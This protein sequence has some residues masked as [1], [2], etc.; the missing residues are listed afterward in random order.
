MLF[1]NRHRP[2]PK[3]RRYRTRHNDYQSLETRNLLAVSFVFESGVLTVNMDQDGNNAIVRNVNGEVTVNDQLVDADAITGGIQALQVS[4]LT[5]LTFAGT[6]GVIDLGAHMAGEFNSGDLVSVEFNNINQA[7]M[8]GLYDV[9]SINGTFVGDNTSFFDADGQ[10]IVN[11]SFNLTSNTSTV[12]DMQNVNNDFRGQINIDTDSNVMIREANDIL[13]GSLNVGTHLT[14]RSLAGDITN[15]GNIHVNGVTTMQ[16]NNVELG[17]GSLVDLN[18]MLLDVDGHFAL[19]EAN[20]VFW[21]GSSQMGST[22]IEAENVSQG[23]FSDVSVVGNAEFDVNRMRLGVGGHNTF[24]T[25]GLNFNAAGHVFI[26]ENSAIQIYGDNSAMDLDLIA[27]GNIENVADSTITVAEISSFQ[28]GQNV[29]IG[30]AANDRFD[31]GTLQFWG[32]IIDVNEDSDMVIDGLANYAQEVVLTA[33]GV[34]TDTDNAYIVV[35]GNARFVSNVTDAASGVMERVTIGDTTSDFFIA[36]TISFDVDEGTFIL[37]ED[38]STQIDGRDGF[39]NH[40]EFAVIRSAG[41]ITNK[42]DTAVIVDKN[43]TFD[44]SSITLGRR[45]GDSFSL[46]SA[47]FKTPGNVVFTEDASVLLG[48]STFVGGNMDIA[49]NGNIQ[50]SQ[51]SFINVLGR[52]SFAGNDIILGDLPGVNSGEPA[53][54][55]FTV[56]PIQFTATG[57]VDITENSTIALATETINTGQTVRLSSVG[58]AQ[59]NGDIT[60]LSGSSLLASGNLHVDA[61]GGI[62]LGAMAGDVI[63]FDNLNFRAAEEVNITAIFADVSDEFFI[64]GSGANKNAASELRLNTNVDVKDGTFAVIEIDEFMR[65]EARNITLGDSDDD[66][67]IIPDD[68]IFITSDQP[69]QVTSNIIC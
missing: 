28:S 40:A 56:G 13:L 61:V 57:D 31:T 64:F 32:D 53:V 51:N 7:T 50:D 43:A 24:N 25:G 11:G 33:D 9:D 10:L 37:H 60:N 67:L 17:A 27:V 14:V 45:V 34:I 42:I 35:E 58:D 21:G 29:N 2:S 69:A 36:G 30:N 49:A 15:N 41:S 66:C 8:N 65:V 38:N 23:P 46:G 16:A 44:G 59:G 5:Q 54:D 1:S 55:N 18:V 3:N 26:Y 52:A 20:S 4:D 47:T 63:N 68:A 39:V 6:N 19:R 48:G 62:S 12:I 22:H